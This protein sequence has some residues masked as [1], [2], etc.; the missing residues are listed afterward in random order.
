MK[1]FKDILFGIIILLIVILLGYWAV[2]SIESGSTHVEKQKQQELEQKNKELEQE[3]EKLKNEIE[4]LEPS[5]KEN[6]PQEETSEEPDI[7]NNTTPFKYQ[8]LINDLQ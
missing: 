6:I 2:V 1:N 8:S 5:V 3:I 7:S 4:A